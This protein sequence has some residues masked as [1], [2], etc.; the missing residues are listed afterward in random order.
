MFQPIHLLGLFDEL[1]P[2]TAIQRW[3]CRTKSK[4]KKWYS[5]ISFDNMNKRKILHIANSLYSLKAERY[6]TI[7][8]IIFIL[9]NIMQEPSKTK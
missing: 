8:E 7:L 2:D 5:N 3:R 9:T 6:R 1:N 4:T